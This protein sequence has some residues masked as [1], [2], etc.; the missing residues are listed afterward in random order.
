MKNSLRLSAF[1]GVVLVFG[2]PLF[3]FDA[4]RADT[5]AFLVDYSLWA[6]VLAKHVNAQGRFDYEGLMKDPARFN[7][8]ISQIENANLS[9]LGPD[10]KKAFWINAYNALTV[11]V[12][13]DNYPV[14]SILRINFGLVWK[15]GR[16]AAGG[17]KSLG[18]IEHKVL[19]PLGD[20]RIHFAINCASIGCPKLSDK[21][22]YPRTLDEQLDQAARQ[23]INDPEKVIIDRQKN[24]LFHSAIFKWFEKDFL[25]AAPDL[26]GYIR[27]YLNDTDKAYLDSSR[28]ELRELDYDWGL[29]RQ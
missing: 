28:P 3:F 29:N 15:I 26:S 11:K 20:P 14:K 5:V 23:F 2:G 27:H 4:A 10:E 12:I 7:Q 8:F 19:R 1:L 22:Y 17:K 9:Q 13:V 21:P 24:I 16:A 25:K 6:D 18:D